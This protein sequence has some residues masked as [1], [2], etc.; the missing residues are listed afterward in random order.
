MIPVV[1]QDRYPPEKGP[2]TYHKLMV[3]TSKLKMP[4][5]CR[6]T[7]PTAPVPKVGGEQIEMLRSVRAL[8]F[9]FAVLAAV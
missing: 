4:I 5:A 9:L 7:S 2:D 3:A 8:V 6:G 1:H